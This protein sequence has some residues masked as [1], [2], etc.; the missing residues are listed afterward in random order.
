MPEE[1]GCAITVVLI[2]DDP[3][4]RDGLRLLIEGTDGFS[5][6]AAYGSVEEALAARVTRGPDVV[7]LDLNLPGMPGSEGVRPLREKWPAA[8]ILMLTVYAEQDRVFESICNG[9]DGYLLKKTP[10]ARLIEALRE[11]HADGAPMSPEIARKVIGLFR[12]AAPPASDDDDLSP[13]ELR[14]LKLLT[15]GYRYQAIA[16]RFNMSLD[17]VRNYIRSIYGKLHVHSKAE[18]VGKAL[19]RRLI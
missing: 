7:L 3:V 12:Q 8:R 11:A 18:A 16:E 5:C 13:H 10:P 17:T 2:E 14:V 4:T 19:R 15:E 6:R 9:A 1:T